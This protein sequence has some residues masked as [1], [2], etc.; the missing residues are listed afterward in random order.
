[1]LDF[2]AAYDIL[3]QSAA[4]DSQNIPQE[5]VPLANCLGRVLADPVR[6]RLDL[7]PF[8]KSAM[9]GFAISSDDASDRFT[10][11][12][13]IA[14][15]DVPQKEI[16]PG[17]CARIMT[18][19]MMPRGA[20]KVIRVEYTSESDGTMMGETPEPYHNVIKMGEN[21]RHGSTVMEPKILRAQ[22]VGILAEQGIDAVPVAVPPLVAVI[23]TGSELIDPG[24]PLE[25]GEIYN[26]NG[27]QLCAQ[28]SAM[29]GRYDYRG[30]VGDTPEKLKKALSE[31]SDRCDIVMLSGGVSMGDFDFVP[32]C[33]TDFGAETIF[34]KVAMKPGKPMLYAR[35]GSTRFIGL[36]GNPVSTFI[37]FEVMVK[38]LIYAIMGMTYRPAVSTGFLSEPISRR[39]AS[40][41]EFKPVKIDHDLITPVTYHGSS[42]LHALAAAD[43]IVRIERGVDFLPEGTKIH[44]RQI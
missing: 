27:L 5:T 32:S 10:I 35:K 33:L 4:P 15:G 29:A 22:D 6:A 3:I 39:D 23:A 31:A 16:T 19:A 28:I 14:A 42:H 40:R 11:I 25:P 38:P 20:D 12:E 7:P 30:I 2:K 1:M 21:I 36:P 18:G 24:H 26:S 9:D 37:I 41:L 44:A 43:G 17:T 34:H 8:A 13:T